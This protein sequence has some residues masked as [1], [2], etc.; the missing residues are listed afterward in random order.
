MT[1]TIGSGILPKV[2]FVTK[3]NAVSHLQCQ[4]GGL[5]P[6]DSATGWPRKT[7]TCPGN[8][9]VPNGAKPRDIN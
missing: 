4:T 3:D 5:P 1:T 8:L 6:D 9:R 7:P 2:P